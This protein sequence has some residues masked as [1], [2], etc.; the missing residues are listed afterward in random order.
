MSKYLMKVL[1]NYNQQL[2]AALVRAEQQWPA[3]CTGK[4]VEPTEQEVEEQRRALLLA[5]TYLDQLQQLLGRQAASPA[6]PVYQERSHA[7]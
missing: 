3:L 5:M 4:D 1:G 7:G 6:Y 2:S